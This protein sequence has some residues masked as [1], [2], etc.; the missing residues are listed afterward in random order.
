MTS[1]VHTVDYHTGGEPF[2]IVS[3]P[4][5]AITGGTVA[6]RR[7]VATDPRHRRSAPTPVLR[8]A[9]ARRHVRRLHHATRRRR[10]AFGVL[11]W[12]KDGFSTACGHG[13]I[14]L[15]R[16]AVRRGGRD[17]GDVTDV[18]STCRPVA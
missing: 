16:W 14:A 13:T 6:E 7:A 10:R 1:Q 18:S 4:P 5:V 9:R 15:G 12:H 3:E 2:R 17:A 8:A 11:F